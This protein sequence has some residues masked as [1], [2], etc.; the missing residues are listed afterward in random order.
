MAISISS[1]ISH[2]PGQKDVEIIVAIIRDDETPI[3]KA[4]Y[5]DPVAG[6]AETDCGAGTRT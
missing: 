4:D 5:S 2:L 1:A 6:L 3:F